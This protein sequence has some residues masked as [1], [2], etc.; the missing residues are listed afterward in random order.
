[1]TANGDGSLCGSIPDEIT[2]THS[3]DSGTVD[4]SMVFYELT[5]TLLHETSHSSLQAIRQALGRVNRTRSCFVVTG[6]PG[7]GKSALITAYTLALLEN[8]APVPEL[9]L[10]D[11]DCTARPDRWALP[12]PIMNA[13]FFSLPRW[14]PNNGSTHQL[15]RGSGL[16]ASVLAG[17]HSARGDLWSGPAC[18]ARTVALPT[19]L[20]RD[21]HAAL[22]RLVDAVI[23]VLRRMLVLALA[24]L[25]H[26]TNAIMFA[27]ILLAACLRYGHRGDEPAHRRSLLIR[28][29]KSSAGKALAVC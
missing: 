9:R 23:A 27:L 8:S 16:A 24:A 3:N 13:A 2:A 5:S 1:V 29:Y 22:L 12:G 26:A 25:S 21:R 4:E 6:P 7:A 19:W 20:T 11:D 10:V 14:A 17:I 28:R 15:E 18:S